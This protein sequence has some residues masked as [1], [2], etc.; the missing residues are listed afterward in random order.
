MPS[1]SHGPGAGKARVDVPEEAKPVKKYYTEASSERKR[2]KKKIF[3]I[4]PVRE[5]KDGQDIEDI[6]DEDDNILCGHGLEQCDICC[7]NHR[8]SNALNQGSAREITFKTVTKYSRT[9][10]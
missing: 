9:H 3:E 2:K 5:F 7:T 6:Y 8:K 4:Q 1:I 10:L